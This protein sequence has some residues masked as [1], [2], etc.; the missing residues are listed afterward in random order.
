V[1]GAQARAPEQT[2][3]RSFLREAA[4]GV[5]G[6]IPEDRDPGNLT[7]P[8]G[9]STWIVK[10]EIDLAQACEAM[11]ALRTAF[12]D[13]SGL[14]RR[15]EP[16]PLLGGDR[17]TSVLTLAVY[18]DGLVDRGARM[19]GTTRTELAEAALDLLAL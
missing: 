7:V 10:S 19:A 3:E 11:L 16:V 15:S 5:A 17:K 9:V 1:R 2:V 18:L 4:L 12:L 13:V 6:I 14:D 8:L